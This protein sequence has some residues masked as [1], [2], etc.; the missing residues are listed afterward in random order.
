MMTMSQITTYLMKMCNDLSF[1]LVVAMFVEQQQLVKHNG[2]TH[3][4]LV[5]LKMY[6]SETVNPF[7]CF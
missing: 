4:R 6:V 2:P 7:N 5:I 1:K 3:L